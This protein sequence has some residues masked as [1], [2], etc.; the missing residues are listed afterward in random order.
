[1]VTVVMMVVMPATAIF[2][3]IN[4]RSSAW[5]VAATFNIGD[6]KT[7]ADTR[8]SSVVGHALQ[9]LPEPSQK[10]L[11][12]Q[13]LNYFH[14]QAIDF[15]GNSKQSQEPHG[16]LEYCH[17]ARNKKPPNRNPARH[18]GLAFGSFMRQWHA[19]PRSSAG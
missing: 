17:V 8:L 19:R 9:T 18:T 7:S 16:A 13:R 10:A 14:R 2:G 11:Y 1:M 3:R 6:H 4:D 5:M 15:K 12:E